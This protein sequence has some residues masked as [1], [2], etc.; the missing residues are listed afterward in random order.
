[1]R[2]RRS[3]TFVEAASVPVVAVTAHQMLFEHGHVETEQVVLVH[4][5]A[6]NVGA[7]CV[8]LAHRAGARVIATA[9]RNDVEYVRALGADQIVDYRNEHFDVSMRLPH[10]LTQS[11]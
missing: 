5:A 8:Q 6:G 9:S 2:W 1:M 3:T 10:C 11:T 4:G 7:Y